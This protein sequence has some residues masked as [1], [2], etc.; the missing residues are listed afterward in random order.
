M[1]RKKF[2]NFMLFILCVFVISLI[3]TFMDNQTN[4]ESGFTFGYSAGRN[5]RHFIE[6]FGSLGLMFLA[7]EAFKG[8]KLYSKPSN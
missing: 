1:T 7:Y 6:I 2:K 8:K 5:F 4:Y 3:Y